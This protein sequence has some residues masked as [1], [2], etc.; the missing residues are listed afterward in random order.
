[1]LFHTACAKMTTEECYRELVGEKD[2]RRLNA[3][4]KVLRLLQAMAR[5]EQSGKVEIDVQTGIPKETRKAQYQER[6]RIE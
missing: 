3:L 4:V 1:M 2:E 5:D 6:S